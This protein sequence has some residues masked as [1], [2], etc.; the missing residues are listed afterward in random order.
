MLRQRSRPYLFSNTV[1]PLIVGAT[2]AILDEL[3]KTTR[4]RDKL[5]EN[6]QFFRDEMTRLGFEIK[7]GETPII[8]IMLYDAKMTTRMA[9]QLLN[10]GIYVIGF[11]FPVVPRGQ[12]RIRVQISA[13]HE[14]EHLEKALTAFDKIGKQLGILT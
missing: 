8:P 10:E 5:S 9:E 4:L 14:K 13:A 3:S 12:A 6:T 2:L 1:T 11:S 7:P